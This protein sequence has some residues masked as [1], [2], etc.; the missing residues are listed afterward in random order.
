MAKFESNLGTKNIGNDGFRTFSVSDESNISPDVPP[1]PTIMNE[2]QRKSELEKKIKQA[3]RDKIENRVSAEAKK[4]I[5]MLAGI[6]RATKE[7]ELE[8]HTFVLRGLNGRDQRELSLLGFAMASEQRGDFQFEI[9]SQILGRALV[10]IDGASFASIVGSD[11][12]DVKMEALE[13]M[14]DA[15]LQFLMSTYRIFSKEN[16]EKYEIKTIDE[17]KEV[18]EDIKK[19]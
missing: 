11:D 15:I 18:I 19:A 5:E 12:L 10:S 6:G 8:G 3:R 4:R 1:S 17:A 2:E 14:D 9:R 16:D 7:V 13:L